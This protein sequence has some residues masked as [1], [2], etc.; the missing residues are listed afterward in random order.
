MLGV[1]AGQAVNYAFVYPNMMINRYGKWMDTNVV[2]PLSAG[3][4]R[5]DFDWWVHP[6][7]ARDRAIIDAGIASSDQ[8]PP[9]PPPLC[10][11]AG[12]LI[13]DLCHDDPHAAGATVYKGRACTF[14]HGTG[15]AWSVSPCCGGCAGAAGGCTAL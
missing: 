11:A 15:G 9:S 12:L 7:L 8:V 14:Q 13:Q 10:S 1:C 6:S 5:V 2:I 4:C 3:Q